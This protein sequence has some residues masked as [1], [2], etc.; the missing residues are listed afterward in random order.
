MVDFWQGDWRRA[1]LQGPLKI[2]VIP[3]VRVCGPGPLINIYI[4]LDF[5]GLEES[6]CVV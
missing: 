6:S 2:H 5:S 4:D 1:T 3:G